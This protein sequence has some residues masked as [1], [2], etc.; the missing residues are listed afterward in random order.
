M[1]VRDAIRTAFLV[2][3]M[4][5]LAAAGAAVAAFVGGAGAQSQNAQSQNLAPNPSLEAA[6]GVTPACWLLGGYGANSY[7]WGRTGASHSGNFA[8]TL[9]VWRFS[10]GDRKLLMGFSS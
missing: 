2:P 4:L 1:N 9:S 7:S 5:T 10:S 6:T 8:E 3:T